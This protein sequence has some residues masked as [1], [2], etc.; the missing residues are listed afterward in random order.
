MH[1]PAHLAHP[2]FGED[3]QRLR[4]RVAAVD[5]DRLPHA[6]GHLELAPEDTLLHVPRGEV[7]EEVE[8]HLA[9]PDHA[10]PAGQ[11]L[12]LLEVG[13]GGVA[14]I[15]RVYPHRGPDVPMPLRQRHGGPIGLAIR[16]DGHHAPQ[17]GGAG[18]IEHRV[19]VLGEVGEVEMRVGVEQHHG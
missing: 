17:S 9:Q 18:A 19:Q 11:A 3:R 7:A 6:P 13:L 2:L 5:D 16:S 15:V 8:P 12:H 1:D 14:G 4:V 10:R